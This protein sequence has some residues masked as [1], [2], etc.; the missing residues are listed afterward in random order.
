MLKHDKNVDSA[1]FLDKIYQK[2]LLPYI[3]AP[4]RITF[5]SRALVLTMKFLQTIISGNIASTV[6]DHYAQF[7]LTKNKSKSKK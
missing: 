4:F 2:F 5:C 3:T 7:F 6:S 1:T